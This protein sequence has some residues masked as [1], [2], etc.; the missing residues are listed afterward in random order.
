[1]KNKSSNG[2]T[3]EMKYYSTLLEQTSVLITDIN[4]A[5]FEVDHIV[6]Y[7]YVIHYTLIH[8]KI[9]SIYGNCDL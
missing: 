2:T 5:T 7:L 3:L 6:V 9:L 1:M 8:L 4:V